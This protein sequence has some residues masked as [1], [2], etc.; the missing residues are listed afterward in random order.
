[1]VTDILVVTTMVLVV[2][3]ALALGA[4]QILTYSGWIP[5][6][7]RVLTPVNRVADTCMRID[8]WLTR[9]LFG[10]SNKDE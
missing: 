9:H 2:G 1:M 6:N 7:H 5:T 4:I 8:D 10:G 3:V